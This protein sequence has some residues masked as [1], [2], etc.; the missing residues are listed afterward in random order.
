MSYASSS[1]PGVTGLNS[2]RLRNQ[3]IRALQSIT[4]HLIYAIRTD[5]DLIKIG[6]TA[7]LVDRMSHIKGGA[8]ELLA[9][10]PGGFTDELAIHR[11]LKGHAAEGR[12]YYLPTPAVLREVNVISV[13]IT[14]HVDVEQA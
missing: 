10:R 12:E 5:D 14:A 8:K 9:L 7:D 11:R 6:C 2:T 1:L 4:G 13:G 3:A